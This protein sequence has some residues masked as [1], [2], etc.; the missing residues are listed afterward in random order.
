[1]EADNRDGPP[2]AQKATHPMK[3]DASAAPVAQEFPDT[4]T[5]R[6]RFLGS[7]ALGAGGGVL[8]GLGV[9]LSGHAAAPARSSILLTAP[10]SA[11]GQQVLGHL[12]DRQAS[13]RVIARDPARIAPDVRQRVDVVEGS[14]GDADVVDKALDG[15]DTVF[16]LCPPDP[17]APSVR[18][19]YVDFS[20][21]ACQAI[22]KRGI[23]RVVGVSALGR[24][25]PMAAH[26]GHVTASL[27]MDDLIAA[28]GAD[29]RALTMPSFMENI[30]RQAAAIRDSGAFFLP[31]DGDRTL[32]AIASGDIA[33]VAA[34]L[35]L[36]HTWDGQ[37]EVPLLGPQ[38]LSFNDMAGI[39]SE[40][41]GKPVQYRRI[42]FDAYRAG[43]IQRG[44]SS[45][46]AQGM[47]D[48][49]R[50]KNEGLDNAV[51][52]TSA[53]STPTSFQR[54]CEAVLRPLVAR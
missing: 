28:T 11:I 16:W 8:A 10:T 12:L 6:R 18:A 50:A 1:M 39:M 27:E 17:A 34:G 53:N 9:S 47:T 54:W 40:V 42:T 21:P 19:A 44:M 43:F 14:H 37:A 23:R 52:R 49:A 38:D 25:T 4:R 22:A 41:L 31:M 20:R 35:L 32:P 7:L 29:F 51:T 33:T 24:G 30:A 13:V 48:M 36:D 3:E 2:F 15:I 26:A 46:M 45:A 5:D